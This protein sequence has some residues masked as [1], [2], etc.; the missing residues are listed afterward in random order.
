MTRYM[1][2]ALALVVCSACVTLAFGQEPAAKAK[3]D[4]RW[5]ENKRIEGLTEEKGLQMSDDPKDGPVYL[6]KKPALVLTAAEVT[7]TDLTKHDF[8]KN[9]LSG[10]LYTV[11]L[12]LSKE[13]REKL[14]AACAGTESRLLTVVVD[15]KPWGFHRYEKGKNTKGVPEVARAETFTPSI[16][17]FSSR[18][19][20]E[21]L[22]NAFK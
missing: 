21:R 7:S 8:S 13:A 6:H 2:V 14:A 20:A 4:I 22:V 5:V 18:A 9:G 11:T 12:H 3:V 10:E 16:G 17:F 1:R 19:E 15:G